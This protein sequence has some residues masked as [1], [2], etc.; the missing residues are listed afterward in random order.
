MKNLKKMQILTKIETK[1]VMKL[2]KIQKNL[3]K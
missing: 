2:A 3:N 1:I